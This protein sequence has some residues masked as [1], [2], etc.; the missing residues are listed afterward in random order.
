MFA[1]FCLG[2]FVRSLMLWR[3]SVTS[4]A[5]RE[6]VAYEGVAEALLQHVTRP[7]ECF[8]LKRKRP[9]ASAAAS[10]KLLKFCLS[11]R[12]VDC[13]TDGLIR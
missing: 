9:F 10:S 1:F 12:V 11:D 5:P 7:R 8:L 13:L 2:S 6:W 3:T 4:R